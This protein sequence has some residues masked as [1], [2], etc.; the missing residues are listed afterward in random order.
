[1]KKLVVLIAALISTG[2][3]IAQDVC[4]VYYPLE[5]GTTFQLT[6]YEKKGKVSAILN[7]EVK[8]AGSDWALL[9]YDIQDAKGK[10]LAT[11]EYEIKCIDDG[12]AVDFK[13]L[14]APGTMEQF[15]DMEIEIS[16]TNLFIPNKLDVGS[17]LPD[18]EMNMAIKGSPIA[19]NMGVKI[20]NRQVSGQE[21]ITTPAGTY[22]CVV[23]SYDFETKMGIKVS[24]SAKQWLAEGVGMVRSEDYN[25]KGKLISWTEL[26]EFN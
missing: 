1:M 17:D 10:S 20:T 21:T 15:K 23:L 9:A 26:T 14:G 16:G 13:S 8:E 12:I 7:Y 6:S 22:N 11:S 4:S 2:A 5:V 18:A 24:G 25:K 3:L 19:M